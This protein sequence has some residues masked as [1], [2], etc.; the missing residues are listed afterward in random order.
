MCFAQYLGPTFNLICGLIRHE[1][2]SPSQIVSFAFF[3]LAIV[4]FTA[5]EIKTMKKSDTTNTQS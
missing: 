1:R 3:I 4:V 2:F 5:S